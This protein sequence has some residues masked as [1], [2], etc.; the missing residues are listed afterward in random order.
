V[1]YN[2]KRQDVDD[3][4]NRENLDGLMPK[5]FRDALKEDGNSSTR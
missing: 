5:V 3:I 4:E 1:F 2:G